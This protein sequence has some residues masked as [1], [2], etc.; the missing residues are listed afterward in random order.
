M[1]PE[2]F[3]FKFLVSLKDEISSLH[4]SVK[5]MLQILQTSFYEDKLKEEKSQLLKIISQL[6]EALQQD[7]KATI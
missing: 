2:T 3:N 1:I 5:K 6:N 4:S 7:K